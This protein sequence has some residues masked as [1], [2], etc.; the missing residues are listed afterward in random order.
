MKLKLSEV[1]QSY[2]YQEIT[3]KQDKS[4]LKTALFKYT[5]PGLGYIIPKRSKKRLHPADVELAIAFCDDIYVTSE[6]QKEL[7]KI[8][9][10]YFNKINLNYQAVRHNRRVLKKFLDYLHKIVEQEKLP[11][12]PKKEYHYFKVLVD[13]FTIVVFL[14]YLLG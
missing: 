1:Y 9:E 8:Q 12:K 13:N 2:I 6:T 7:T 11:A 14:V 5:L 10:K 3:N 4:N